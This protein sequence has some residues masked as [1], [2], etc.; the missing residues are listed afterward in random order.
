MT[1]GRDVLLDGGGAAGADGAVATGKLT[2]TS[3]DVA[4][5]A[6]DGS[7]IQ[8]ADVSAGDD[9]VLRSTG[10]IQASG[11]IATTGQPSTYGLGDRL[12]DPSEGG[13]LTIG[14]QTFGLADS[15]IDVVGDVV[16][17]WRTT[18]AGSVRISAGNGS[19]MGGASVGIDI[20]IDSKAALAVGDLSALG[21]IALRARGGTLSVGDLTAG[22]DIV[23]RA[24]QGITAG[25]LTTNGAEHS[26]VGDLLFASD[27]TGLNGSFDLQGST[28]DVKSTSGP[29]SIAGANSAG[30]VRLQTTGGEVTITGVVTAGQDIF[31][32]GDSVSATGGL[33]AG[34]DV[35]LYGRAGG[36]SVTSVSAGNDLV[37]RAAG[38]VTA[39]GDLKSGQG[40]AGSGV[41]AT[42]LTAT[43]PSL[44]FGTAVD[45]GVGVLDLR[46][47]K[48][49]ISG[50][51]DAENGG[52]VRLQTAGVATL[53]D[54][55]AGGDIAIDAAGDLTTG[56]LKA[57]RDIGL[58]SSTGAISLASAAAGDD[59]VLRAVN[60]ITISGAVSV[61]GGAANS[62][63]AGARLLAASGAVSVFGEAVDPGVGA[64][65]LR[66]ANIRIGGPI[67]AAGGGAALRLRSTGVTSLADAS[68]AGE[69][70]IDAGGDVTGGA[71]KAGGDL[72]LRSSIGAISLASAAAGDDLVLR[73]VKDVTV[74]GSLTAG[75]AADSS[76]AGDALFATDPTVL[77][78]NLSLAGANIDIRTQGAIAVG[79]TATA[80]G[81]A[82]FQTVGAG[83][84]S[85]AAV[86][87]GEDVLADGGA[88]QATGTLSAGRD[89]AV[90]GRAGAVNLAS[91][92]AGDN[93]A[94]RAAGDVSV[95]G[96]VSSG[97]GPS[98]SGAADRLVSASESGEIMRLV[99]PLATTPSIEGFALAAGDIDIMSGG[100]ISF[101]GNITG[102]S[103]A[104]LHLQAAGKISAAGV[105]VGDSIF[106]RGGDFALGGVWSA[107]SV[108][109]EVTASGGLAL[110]DGVSAPSGGVALSN[111][112][113]NLIDAPTLQI[114]LGDT[115]GTM[116]GAALSIGTLSIDPAKI[117][118]SLELYA[119]AASQV[120][121]SGAF[122]PSSSGTSTTAVRIGAPNADVGDWT[123]GSIRVIADNG[124]SIG[125]ST[126]AGGRTFSDVRAFGVHVELNAVND[127]LMGYPGLH[128]QAFG[129]AGL[130][131][132]ASRQG[133]HRPAE[134]ER[135]AHA[136]HR[137]IVDAAGERQ[138]GSAGHRG[139]ARHDADRHLP[140][141][142]RAGRA[143]AD[144]GPHLDQGR[145]RRHP[146]GIHR[147]QRRNHHGR[148][149]ADGVERLA[150]QCDRLRQDRDAQLL[151][152]PELLR[153]PPAGQL[154]LFDRPCERQH[155]GGPA[156]QPD[157]AGPDRR[158]RHGRSDGRQRHQ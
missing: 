144:P 143:A 47:T 73:A 20:L 4:V 135:A 142:R 95:S 130:R 29:I 52:A 91:L 106:A 56:A 116:R 101:A 15:D 154:H 146:A 16:N 39:S 7:A 54:A 85:L 24:A 63:G 5:R 108:R 37:V 139:P 28:V 153:H 26:G 88:V 41:G 90:R 104:S 115:S 92:S 55:S 17:L 9:V 79:G 38:D 128:R 98:A 148:D 76:G 21:D 114:F 35:A 81:D 12:A 77:A 99:D 125:F 93:I 123:P 65:D 42:L 27:P 70:A 64:I 158:R 133:D 58:R 87:A 71:L 111:S 53:A 40:A 74:S 118:T 127:I 138:G 43:G 32:D 89:V 25:M 86:S 34:R 36:V 1:A 137:G 112:T 103:G 94:I 61:A 97:S 60:D 126:T 75:G 156:D 66:G 48:I 8:L 140:P 78:G 62:D 121:I 119:G 100:A 19:L 67:S 113:I 2:A 23:L 13:A 141:E 33:T 30:D 6:R 44:L 49:R 150:R 31:A 102:G 109:L 22:D 145:R 14:G 3:G 149:T 151:L 80:A 45:P 120:T 131:G 18:A 152:S 134:C 96:A 105:T 155:L 124:G 50:S 136:D 10:D 107:N 129:D 46:G 157:G 51:V 132:R 147:T 69:I 72:A 57:G 68:V 11:T 84:I 110:G 122:A 117:K 82:R 83:G 59:V